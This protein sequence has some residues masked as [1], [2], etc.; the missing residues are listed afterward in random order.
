M[1]MGEMFW[2]E[3]SASSEGIER[4]RMPVEWFFLVCFSVEGGVYRYLRE[5]L[6]GEF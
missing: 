3:R 4:A 6:G 2:V 1:E 5:R